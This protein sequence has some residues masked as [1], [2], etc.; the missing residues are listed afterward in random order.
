M[1]ASY[2]PNGGLPAYHLDWMVAGAPVVV[3]WDPSPYSPIHED[4]IFGQTEALLQAASVPATVV[5]WGGDEMVSP[6]EWCAYFGE[7]TGFEP[8][9]QLVV[10]D[11]TLRGNT[12]DNTK[13]LS[14]TGPCTVSWKDGFKR[15]YE[16]RYPGGAT[17]GEPV[18]GQATKL[19]AASS[20]AAPDT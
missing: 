1:N 2:G 16:E 8:K 6:Q 19:L 12:L 18:G 11:G 15:M 9:F 7:L 10:V 5:N 3:R 20:K 4:D 17:F 14:I 13:R